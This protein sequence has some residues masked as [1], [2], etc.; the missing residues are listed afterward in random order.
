[1][2][3]NIPVTNMADILHRLEAGGIQSPADRF[4]IAEELLGGPGDHLDDEGR[5]VVLHG[6]FEYDR[7]GWMIEF[8]LS[9]LVD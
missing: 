8:H 1:M 6:S 7:R 9:P 4:R 3:F 2:T 5:D